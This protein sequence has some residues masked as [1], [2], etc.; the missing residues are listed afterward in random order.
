MNSQ[1]N[2]YFG[3]TSSS[4]KNSKTQNNFTNYR[5]EA[6]DPDVYYTQYNENISLKK[7]LQ[8]IQLENRKLSAKSKH[9]ETENK[10]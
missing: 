1:N 10:R 6:I 5:N 4:K 2:N 3:K 9:L 7:Q 8:Q